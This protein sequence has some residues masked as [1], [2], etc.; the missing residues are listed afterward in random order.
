MCY[1]TEYAFRTRYNKG[2]IILYYISIEPKK[3]DIYIFF[4]YLTDFD[5]I[6]KLGVLHSDNKFNTISTIIPMKFFYKQL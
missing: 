1:N 2:N 4:S 3:I 5:K 6:S